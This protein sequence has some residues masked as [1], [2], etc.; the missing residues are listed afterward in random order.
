MSNKSQSWFEE[1]VQSVGA[2]PR[3]AQ[4]LSLTAPKPKQLKLTM[5]SAASP[6]LPNTENETMRRQ[7]SSRGQNIN[8]ST[9]A[10]ASI[11]NSLRRSVSTV[12]PPEAAMANA[13]GTLT[14]QPS[15]IADSIRVQV[16]SAQQIP[17]PAMEGDPPTA[18]GLYA[19]GHTSDTS[20]L[21]NTRNMF[22]ES[23]NPLER[24]YRDP[25]KGEFYSINLSIR[26]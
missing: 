9:P 22:V 23:D 1:K 11:A 18:N 5:G 7:S 8:G 3:V 20:L 15:S 4:R 24:K 14:P 19:N 13:N 2:P 26:I 25:G 6:I 10:P 12:D 21:P 16:A 17:T